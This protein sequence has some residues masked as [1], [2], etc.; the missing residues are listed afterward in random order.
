MAPSDGA[1]PVPSLLARSQAYNSPSIYTSSTETE[2]PAALR[3]SVVALGGAVASLIQIAATA[4]EYSYVPT[5]WNNTS[6]LLRR[7]AALLVCLAITLAPTIWI[8][9]FDSTSQ[10][11]L[12]VGIVQFALAVVFVVMFSVI[13]S[14]RL[15]GDRVTGKSRKYLASQTFTASYPKLLVRQR[16]ASI[17]LWVLIFGCKLTE[18]YFFLTLSFENPVRV[19][20]GMRV[21]TCNDALFG[22]G[23]CRYQPAFALAIMF[24]MDVC[25]FFLDT[26][27]WYVIWNTGASSLPFF[28]PLP[29]SLP[30]SPCALPFRPRSDPPRFLSAQ[31][32]DPVALSPSQSTR[33][34]ARSRSACRSGR[35]GRVRRPTS[36]PP[37]PSLSLRRPRRRRRRRA[38]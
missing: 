25:L 31:N 12:I 15:F 34:R 21:Q 18:S 7:T 20:V 8:A 32:P 35:R 23:L 5:T 36:L 11:A 16:V 37:P 33:S 30:P 2:P 27:L 19:M 3:W 38:A 1:D 13:P 24:C 6:H 4:A 26:F 29:P 9:G 22:N 17:L 28:A 10:A 14:G